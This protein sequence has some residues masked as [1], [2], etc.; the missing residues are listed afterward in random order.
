MEWE[1]NEAEGGA[2]PELQVGPALTFGWEVVSG[3]LKTWIPATLALA[4]AAVIPDLMSTYLQEQGATLQATLVWALGVLLMA[5]LW[6][7]MV[8]MSLDAVEGTVVELGTLTSQAHLILRYV[9]ASFIFGVAFFVGSLFFVIPGLVVLVFLYFYDYVMV[10]R[11]AGVLA[12]LRGSA[13][14]G[15]GNRLRIFFFLL[16]LL[17]LNIVGA[18]VFLVGLLL[19]LPITY[20]ASAH[21]YRQLTTASSGS[22]SEASPW[23]SPPPS[24]A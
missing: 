3:N 19:T 15:E 24:S 16:A 13:D 14:L 9:V 6:V 11:Q 17:V 8:R 10:D 5:F 7:G 20:V 2:A 12:S 23:R 4:A 1:R 18:L 21:A 22:S